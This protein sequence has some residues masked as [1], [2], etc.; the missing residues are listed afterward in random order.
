[1]IRFARETDIPAVRE[2]WEQCFPDEGGFN[3]YFF[4]YFFD[5]QRTLLLTEGDTLCAMVQMLPY[6]LETAAG[7][8]EVTYIY[9]ACTHPAHRRKGH[10]ARLLEHSFALDRAAGRAASML[11]PAEKWLFDF[12]RPFGYEPFFHVSRH[13]IVQ[14]GV[15]DAPRR[16]SAADVPQMAALYAK[17]TP[18]CRVLRDEAYWNGQLALFDALGVGVF[19]WF[20][21]SGMLAAYAFCWADHA[22]ETLGMT[23]ARE[24]GLLR[25]LGL[26]RMVY[27]TYGQEHALG[28]IKWHEDGQASC[29][30]MNLMLN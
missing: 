10:M 8:R 5:V 22:Q 13:E 27:T 7:E 14:S 20:D 19:G 2:L 28:C 12:Y 23:P 11:I 15:G 1:M 26:D 6:R 3:P 4:S 16:L 30:Y 25:A 21:E 18:A 17:L 24:Q 9:G 29:G